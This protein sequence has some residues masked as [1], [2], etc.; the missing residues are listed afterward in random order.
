MSSWEATQ[1]MIWWKVERALR[2]KELFSRVSSV[3]TLLFAVDG[4]FYS[5]GADGIGNVFSPAIGEGNS[6]VYQPQHI[7]ELVKEKLG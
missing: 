6:K 3:G 1:R 5:L 4:T 7:T 2:S